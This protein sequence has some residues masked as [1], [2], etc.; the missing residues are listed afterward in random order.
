MSTKNPQSSWEEIAAGKWITEGDT[1]QERLPP[2]ER[3]TPRHF[4]IVGTSGSHDYLKDPMDNRRFWPL[5]EPSSSNAAGA[6]RTTHEETEELIKRLLTLYPDE[7]VH[8]LKRS[9]N[10]DDGA[11]QAEDL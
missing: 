6:P 1:S 3:R 8:V 7:P 10:E 5:S 2:K 9:C 11:C 4:L